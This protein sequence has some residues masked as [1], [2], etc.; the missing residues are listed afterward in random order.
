[1]EVLVKARSATLNYAGTIRFPVVGARSFA[2][3]VF[4]F[5]AVPSA[6]AK[7]RFS[8]TSRPFVPHNRFPRFSP[9]K[10]RKRS[11][12]RRKRE[13]RGEKGH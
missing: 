8:R 5:S 10:K 3:L 2:N 12:G 11:E 4:F 9:D 6:K 7:T 13:K 1:M